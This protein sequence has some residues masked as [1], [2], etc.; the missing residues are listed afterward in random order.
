MRF[1][2]NFGREVVN[3]GVVKILGGGYTF[4]VFYCIFIIK[5]LEGICKK[6]IKELKIPGFFIF[7]IFQAYPSCWYMQTD[8]GPKTGWQGPIAMRQG[9]EHPYLVAMNKKVRLG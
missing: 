2:L 8:K 5:I 1:L 7:F 6:T 4:L 3:I 9:K